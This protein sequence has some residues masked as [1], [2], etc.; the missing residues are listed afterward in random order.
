M[1][2]MRAP[3]S[4]EIWADQDRVFTVADMEDMPDDEFRYELDDGMLIMSPA[5]SLP[6]QIAVMHLAFV[7][8]AVCPPNLLV[9]PGP[10][11][12]INK[13][14]HR[15]P[16]IAVIRKESVTPMFLEEPPLLAVEVASPRTRVYDR[17][18]KRDV[19]EK[20]GIRS[21]WIVD[22]GQ[23][24]PSLTVLELH[25]GKYTETARVIGDERF[26]AVRPFP[27]RIVPA[28]LV[29]TGSE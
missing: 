17:G 8:K 28:D 2:V 12:N 23:D 18:R 7:L 1:S 6:H 5:P 25:R 4:P 15:V 19:Y 27:V 14:Q 11:V 22:V 13:F 21:Y 26:D 10:G 24:K 20:F 3:E 16:D 29:A 9:V